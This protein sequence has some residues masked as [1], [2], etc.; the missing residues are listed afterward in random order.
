MKNVVKL[1]ESQLQNL[2][3]ESVKKVL[4]EIT[5]A[6][7]EVIGKAKELFNRL[8]TKDFGLE[9]MN[10]CVDPPYGYEGTVSAEIDDENGRTWT[11]F[12]GGYFTRTGV[13][14]YELE[15]VGGETE[16]ETSDGIKGWF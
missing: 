14:D 7:P 16:F 5:N 10:D 15:D 11:F 3:R 6:S 12:T 1:N 2:I 8:S 4:N 13:D 9:E